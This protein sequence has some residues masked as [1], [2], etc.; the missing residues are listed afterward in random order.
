MRIPENPPQGKVFK[1]FLVM[2]IMMKIKIAIAHLLTWVCFDMSCLFICAKDVQHI[3]LCNRCALHIV[4]HIV[5]C[6]CC[7]CNRQLLPGKG[8]SATFCNYGSLFVTWLACIAWVVWVALIVAEW[9]SQ[10]VGA[11]LCIIA[12]RA[13]VEWYY[14]YITMVKMRTHR[15]NCTRRCEAYGKPSASKQL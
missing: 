3:V 2:L 14:D 1:R 13:S 9:K 7:K 12:T 4:Q 15:A 5:Q 6:N 10:K 11:A 8:C